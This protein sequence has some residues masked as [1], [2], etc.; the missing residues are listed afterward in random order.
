MK[1]PMC[2]REVC[3]IVPHKVCYACR[4]DIAFELQLRKNPAALARRLYDK[5]QKLEE[6]ADDAQGW[7]DDARD[8]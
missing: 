3:S 8:Y 1:C 4:E 7:F 6:E 5:V 2:Q